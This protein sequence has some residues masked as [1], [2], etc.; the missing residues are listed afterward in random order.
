MKDLDVLTSALS[1]EGFRLVESKFGP[2][3]SGTAEF[4]NEKR[5]IQVIKDRSQWMLKGPRQMLEP[6]GL[7]RA[8]DNT[9]DFRDAL[10]AYVKKQE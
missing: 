4:S 2:M 9:L 3:D 8:F 5:R 1:I 7:F 6:L 10:V